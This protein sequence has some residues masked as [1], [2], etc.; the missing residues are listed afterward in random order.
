MQLLRGTQFFHDEFDDSEKSGKPNET[1]D[2]NTVFETNG[3]FSSKA[4][5]NVFGVLFQTIV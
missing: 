1:A 2:V 5:R 4:L 3:N